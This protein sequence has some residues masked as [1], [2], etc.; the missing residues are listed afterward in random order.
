MSDEQ[1]IRVVGSLVGLALGERTGV[2]HFK[3]AYTALDSPVH[4]GVLVF[5]ELLFE[6]LNLIVIAQVRVG[7]EG[8]VTLDL[9]RHGACADAP[10]IVDVPL[11]CNATATVS[12]VVEVV[13]N[14]S[15]V[16]RLK[17]VNVA[18]V[19]ASLKTAAE[20]DLSPI[21]ADRAAGPETRAFCC[22][23][24][25]SNVINVAAFLV[26]ED[27]TADSEVIAQR[28]IQHG[29]HIIVRLAIFHSRRTSLNASVET[30]G[31]GFVR[32]QTHHARLRACAK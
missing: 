4:V 3:R 30:R 6:A 25:A 26:R 9:L 23:T 17:E 7:V 20:A 24:C 11:G 16:I 27:H 13:L 28:D 14:E 10:V 32:D 31:V 29:A 1:V 22:C 21:G 8:A 15:T 5:N 19:C 12:G 2:E 18:Q